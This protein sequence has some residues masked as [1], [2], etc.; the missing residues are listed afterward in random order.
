MNDKQFDDWMNAIREG[1][2]FVA[3]TIPNFSKVKVTVKITLLYLKK[4]A[5][6]FI[7]AFG[8]LIKKRVNDIYLISSTLC[9]TYLFAVK[10][11]W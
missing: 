5:L 4:W 9:S 6:T 3:I 8:L 2:D 11:K 10:S 1:R 7:N